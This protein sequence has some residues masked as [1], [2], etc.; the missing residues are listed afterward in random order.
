MLKD[1]QTGEGTHHKA[2]K[3]E[4]C[5]LLKCN[6]A[7]AGSAD[8]DP[9]TRRVGSLLKN[10]NSCS[11]RRLEAHIPSEHQQRSEPPYG[12]VAQTAL[13]AA[14]RAVLC[15]PRAPENALNARG[16]A[17]SHGAQRSA[18]PTFQCPSDLGHTLWNRLKQRSRRRDGRGLV[19]RARCRRAARSCRRADAGNGAPAVRRPCGCRAGGRW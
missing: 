18:R 1:L 3:K 17:P 16:F 15:T 11:S 13:L 6:A 9:T 7:R 2:S 19:N 5:R 14:G 4:F 8:S 10:S 12:R